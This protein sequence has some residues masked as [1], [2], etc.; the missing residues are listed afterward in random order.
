MKIETPEGFSLFGEPLYNPRAHKQLVKFNKAYEEWE[1]DPDDREK[2]LWLGRQHAY[3]GRYRAA[4]HIFTEGL[5]K[6][7]EDPSSL[8]TGRTGS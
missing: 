6:F 2:I 3:V 1:R 8:G 4:I 5:K 7:P